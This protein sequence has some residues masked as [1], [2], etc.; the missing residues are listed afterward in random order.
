MTEIICMGVRKLDDDVATLRCLDC[1]CIFNTNEFVRDIGD[2]AQSGLDAVFAK[3]PNCGKEGHKYRTWL[4]M[5]KVET[6]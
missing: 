4:K 3:C 2:T 1:G 5:E 6:R